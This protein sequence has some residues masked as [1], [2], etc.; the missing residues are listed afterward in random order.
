MSA[1]SA[2]VIKSNFEQSFLDLRGKVE[3][4]FGKEASLVISQAWEFAKL[5][6]HGQLRKSGEEYISHPLATSQLLYDWGLDPTTIVAGLLHDVIEDGG[7]TTSDLEENFGPEVAS[8]VDGVSVVSNIRLLGSRE[9]VFVESLRKMILTMAHDL[10][11]VFVKFA[12]R[13]HNMRTIGALPREKQ[14][15]IARE[16]LEVFAPLAERLGMGQV[17]GVMEDLCFKTLHPKEYKELK[18]LVLEM[19]GRADKNISKMSRKIQ[20]DLK[21]E[22]IESHVSGRR[23]NTY[24]LWKKLKREEIGGDVTKIHDIVAIRIIVNTVVEC[25]AALGVVHKNYKPVPYLGISDFIAQPKPNGYQSIHTKVFG[26]GGKIVEVQIR[27]QTMHEEAEMGA[28]AHWAYSEAKHKGASDK[29][30]ESGKIKVG[31]SK[32]AWVSQLVTWQKQLTDSKEFLNAVKFDALSH[33]NYVFS[34][35]GDVYE[36]PEGATPI[37]FAFSVHTQ[38]GHYIKAAMVNGKIVPLNTRLISGDVVSI[39]KSKKPEAPNK[40]WL[41]FVVTNQA[42]K[43]IR[44]MLSA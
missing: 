35:K 9:A 13:I 28:A 16:T 15:K 32:L 22:K 31:D 4:R 40:N 20:A 21:H 11:V 34:P 14:L 10:R 41:D 43:G 30:L 25:Y 23:K 44:R 6:H 12:D 24:S 7:A 42:K 37:D 38:L 26:E 39:I 29:D 19:S 33:K 3:R 18:Y 27:T 2:P 36:L 1:S 17:K 5:A 8:L